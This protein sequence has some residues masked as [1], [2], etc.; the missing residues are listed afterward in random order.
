MHFEN[1]LAAGEFPV[2]VDLETLFR[3]MLWLRRRT[4]L[5]SDAFQLS[6]MRVLL[7]PQRIYCVRDLRRR[8]HER[9][10][11]RKSG[12]HYPSRENLVLG[13]GG[14][15]RNAT[16]PQ[17]K[18]V[19]IGWR[20]GIVRNCE[21]QDVAAGEYVEAFVTGFRCGLPF[22]RREPRRAA[23]DRRDT[24][25]LRGGRSAVCRASHRHLRRIAQ[26]LPAPRPAEKRHRPGSSARQSYGWALRSRLT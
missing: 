9:R 4:I 22:D 6:V 16:G 7:L 3:M 1:L 15:G 17:T 19:P 14:N 25:S 5:R 13:E 12:Q 21:G 8:R 10:S 23:G 18:T 2:P 20:C 11:A 26:D 24:G